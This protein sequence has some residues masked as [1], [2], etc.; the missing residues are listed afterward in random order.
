MLT[1]ILMLCFAGI[2]TW[3]FGSEYDNYADFETTLQTEFELLF[4][5][6]AHEWKS[7]SKYA[8]LMGPSHTCALFAW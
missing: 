7:R 6:Q 8:E 3:R 1:T 5:N 2:G 4:G